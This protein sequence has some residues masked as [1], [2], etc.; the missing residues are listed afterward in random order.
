MNQVTATTIRYIKLGAGGRWEAALDRGRL[1]WGAANDPHDD[2]LAGEW[3]KVLA[4]YRVANPARG[5]A[6]GYTNEAR[7][8]YDRDS[9]VMWIT[10]ARG[11]MW[12][13]FAEP[14]V[15]W[16]GGDGSAEG[17]RYRVAHGGWSDR[18]AAGTRL[19]MDRLSTSLTQLAGYR[20]TL[21]SLSPTQREQCLRYINA[22]MDP[23]QLAVAAARDTLRHSLVALIRR[24]SWSDFEQLVDL[25]LS[26]S[27]W[28]RVSELG[29]ME[30][31][32]DLVVEQPLTGA[33]MAVQVKSSA[34]QAVV[35][36]Y[37]R[38]LDARSADEQL[39]LVCHSPQGKLAPPA[40]ASG[41][42][43]DLMLPERLVDLS[44]NAGLTDWIVARAR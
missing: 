16:N 43:F 1:D 9:E 2:A 19:D 24:L 12:W 26:R 28:V 22:A 25:A 36:E 15:V 38:R 8:F 35:D 44:I 14:E 32:V 18:D 7:A 30:K 33:R 42:P 27:G 3:D 39:M 11:R 5:T 23:E 37:A 4:H 40:T 13:T 41:R 17:T 10:F 21:C 29:K 34:T 31:D 6:T 20:R